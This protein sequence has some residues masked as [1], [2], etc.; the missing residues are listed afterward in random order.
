MQT[1]F[2]AV[3][4]GFIYFKIMSDTIKSGFADVYKLVSYHKKCLI[5]EQTGFRATKLVSYIVILYPVAVQ[6]G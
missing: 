5:T 1:D 2:T 6:T 4:A 3:Q